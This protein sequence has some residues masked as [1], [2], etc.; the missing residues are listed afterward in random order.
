MIFSKK[1][2]WTAKIATLF[3]LVAAVWFVFADNTYAQYWVNNPANCPATYSG[4]NCTP[5]NVCGING[6][7]AECYD[8]DSISAP[9]SSVLS[10]TNQDTAGINAGS[11]NGGYIL[12]CYALDAGAPF[13]DNTAAW[14]CDYNTTCNT[15]HVQTSC[16]GGQMASS[17]CSATCVG[18]YYACDGS[19]ADADGC[20][21]YSN[22]GD[23]S[24][25]CNLLDGG[26]N[27]N[28][29]VNTS[30]ACVCDSNYLDCD[31]GGA[32]ATN[33]CE[34][35]NGSACTLAGLPGVVNGC[36]GGAA[37]CVISTSNFITG[38]EAK[39]ST[40]TPLLW[41]TQYGTGYLA[42]LL[43]N[44]A[45]TT[46]GVFT[47]DNNGRVGIGTTTPGAMLTVGTSSGSQFLVNNSGVVSDGTWNGDTIGLGY[48]GLGADFSG[49]TGFL[50]V[51]GGI[52]TA[53]NTISIARTDLTA[54]S[55]LNLNG[56]ILSINT[57]GDWTGTLD[58]INGNEIFTL[59]A[60]F[61]TSTAPQ[62][63][64]L[65]NLSTVGTINSGTWQGNVIDVS[66][67]GTGLSAFTE[68]SLV[69]ASSDNVIGEIFAGGENQVLSI[70]GGVPTWSDVLIITF[71]LL[72]TLILRLIRLCEEL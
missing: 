67:G 68:N 41:G 49:S 54:T 15:K 47:I 3:L 2:I 32:N 36:S 43:S 48:G 20:E 4:Q 26:I 17:T 72:R 6:S 35:Q 69:Y 70:V 5:N 39:Y 22:N 58:G 9:G 59:N 40:T 63:T 64:S 12:N 21:V 16:I 18:T 14:W 13:C 7:T 71:Y 44:N 25:N 10:N 55:P 61:S 65:P 8:T 46:G 42:K 23:A 53:S 60:W 34:V 38:T 30:C 11:F 27:A 62:L 66:Y 33:G 45:S 29:H 37:N 28:N 19:S 1:T 57:S 52:T 56:N 24:N 31:G 50:Y 51:S